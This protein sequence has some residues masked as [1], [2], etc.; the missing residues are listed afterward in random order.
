[1]E[2][3][4]NSPWPQV[5]R[6]RRHAIILMVDASYGYGQRY[7]ARQLWDN[8]AFHLRGDADGQFTR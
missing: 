6:G 1:M 2:N 5:K 3:S 4:G 7:E 8:A